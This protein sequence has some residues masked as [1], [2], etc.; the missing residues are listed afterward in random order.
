MH[1]R[2]AG[3]A[4]LLAVIGVSIV[5]GVILGGKLNAPHVVFAAPP[6]SVRPLELALASPTPGLSV[7]FADIVERAMPA[8]VSVTSLQ[9]AAEEKSERER[10]RPED[11]WQ[12]FFGPD[13]FEDRPDRLPQ[14]R[15]GEG[16]GF[17]IS[18]DGYILTN[19]HV[20]Q[21]A[22][23]VKVGLQDGTELT[24]DVVG[25]DPSIDLALLKVETDE[26]L[27]TLPLGDSTTLRV[28]EWVIAIGNPLNY[29]QTVTV[30]VVSAKNRR[31]PLPSTDRSGLVTF[32]QTDAA[33]NFGNSGGPL[34]DGRGNVIGIN[35]AI[36]R[37]NHAEGIGFALPIDQARRVI[38]Q[39]RETGHVRR[40]YL[41]ISMNAN[42]VNEEARQYYGLPDSRG[43]IIDH[44]ND[45]SPAE[46]AGIEPGDIIRK[47]DG[48]RVRDNDD[49]LGRIATRRPGEK[50]RVGV[51]REGRNLD[52]TVTLAERPLDGVQPASQPSRPR[53]DERPEESSGLGITVENLNSRWRDRLVWL[54][55][56][57]QGVVVTEVDF[58]SLAAERNVGR[59]MVITDLNGEAIR[60]VESW[61]SAIERLRPGQPVRLV[62]LIA[63]PDGI[64]PRAFFLRAPQ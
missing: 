46:K 51:F 43:V 26:T 18:E 44:V 25:T 53:E 42:G 37:I 38:G 15:I 60:D 21:D 61:N 35:T 34:I 52:M 58:D 23:Q 48:E 30:G 47:V 10:G 56:R 33:I 20:V 29:E 36:Q 39:L 6:E 45:G 24:A 57:Q 32:I 11:F 40:G 27:P 3:F 19:N 22:D 13:D 50:V 55:D 2:T 12:W 5:F 8:V 7:S 16:S 63:T 49:L 31:V 54:G 1:N 59:G 4:S 64:T 41:G 62:A 9:D 14:P 17:I 28:G